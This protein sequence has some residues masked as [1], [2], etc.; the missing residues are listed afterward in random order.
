MSPGDL[1]RLLCIILAL[2]DSQ[3]QTYLEDVDLDGLTERTGG[4]DSPV[5]W[6]WSV[7]P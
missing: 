7:K 3:I 2:A 6:N 1:N 4:L 5:D